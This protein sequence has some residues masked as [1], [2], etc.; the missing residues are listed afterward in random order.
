M[1]EYIHLKG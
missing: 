1:K